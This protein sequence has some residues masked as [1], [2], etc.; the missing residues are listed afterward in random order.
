MPTYSRS[1][2]STMRCVHQRLWPPL[3]LCAF[4]RLR[5]LVLIRIFYNSC[6]G[7]DVN[8]W[9][10][11]VISSEQQCL[12]IQRTCSGEKRRPEVSF[13]AWRTLTGS[14]WFC[15]SPCDWSGTL[16]GT[17]VSLLNFLWINF[18]IIL[19]PETSISYIVIRYLWVMCLLFENLSLTDVP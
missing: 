5:N 7:R 8:F 6:E 15:T 14:H 2:W 16:S 17:P 1:C 3:G 10:C 19:I 11:I 18:I 4:V 9:K 13:M 12:E